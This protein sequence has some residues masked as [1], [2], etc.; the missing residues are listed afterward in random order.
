MK[1]FRTSDVNVVDVCRDVFHF[2]PCTHCYSR[3][4]Y[5][6]KYG[7]P[8]RWDRSVA[9]FSNHTLLQSGVKFGVSDF[10]IY[11]RFGTVPV[12]DAE[13]DRNPIDRASVTDP[14]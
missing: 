14:R 5:Q 8:F 4:A 9:W 13:T 7:G 11:N 12:L 3:Q 6:K 2:E 10:M 1:P